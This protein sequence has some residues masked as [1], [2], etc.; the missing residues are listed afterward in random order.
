ML[1]VTCMNLLM[2]SATFT[3][4]SEHSSNAPFQDPVAPLQPCY[5]RL[6]ASASLERRNHFQ[7]GRIASILAEPYRLLRIKRS[8][9]YFGIHRRD[10]HFVFFLVIEVNMDKTDKRDSSTHTSY[11]LRK[12]DAG[13]FSSQADPFAAPPWL[14]AK[15]DKRRFKRLH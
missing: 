11:T 15:Q 5:E 9:V 1:L 4:Q 7:C 8:P 3:D 2:N 14:Y 10:V 12:P 6:E 13:A